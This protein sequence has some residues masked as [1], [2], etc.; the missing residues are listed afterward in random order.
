MLLTMTIIGN[1]CGDGSR[2]GVHPLTFDEGDLQDVTVRMDDML[3]SLGLYNQNLSS[4]RQSG[5]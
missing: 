1:L 2:S 5:E 3:K 4:P